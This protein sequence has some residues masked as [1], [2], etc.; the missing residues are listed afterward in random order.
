METSLVNTI[1][2]LD[3]FKLLDQVPLTVV[4][5]LDR[6]MMTFGELLNLQDGDVIGLSRAAGENIRVYVG[7]AL[8]G[9]GEILLLEGSLAIRIADLG[10][11]GRHTEEEQTPEGRTI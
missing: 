4:A 8:I 11:T 9:W 2:A 7:G 5:E 3:G 10:E 1:P 6:K